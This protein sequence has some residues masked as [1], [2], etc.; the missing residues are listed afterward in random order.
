MN[1]YKNIWIVYMILLKY[2]FKEKS[3]E[4]SVENTSSLFPSI[5]ILKTLQLL[6]FFKFKFKLKT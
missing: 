5:K 6:R 4:K 3:R 2:S 1:T